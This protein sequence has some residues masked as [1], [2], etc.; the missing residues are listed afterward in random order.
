MSRR[1]VRPKSEIAVTLTQAQSSAGWRVCL[2]LS[3]APPMLPS[4]ALR[5]E[6]TFGKTPCPRLAG[7]VFRFPRRDAR[8]RTSQRHFSFQGAE[9]LDVTPPRKTEPVGRYKQEDKDYFPTPT[10]PYSRAVPPLIQRRRPRLKSRDLLVGEGC[11]KFLGGGW[12]IQSANKSTG[13]A[14]AVEAVH[15]RILPLHR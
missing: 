12:K 6:P 9:A 15:S 14:R 5:D 7:I 1:G 3:A 10:S 11:I 4:K 2:E 13:F 8:L